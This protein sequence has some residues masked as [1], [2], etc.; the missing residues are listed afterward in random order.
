MPSAKDLVHRI[1][2]AGPLTSEEGLSILKRDRFQCQYCGLDGM[3][4]FENSL[5]MSVDFV[6]PRARKGK[7]DP[8]NL[9]AACRPC[10]VIKGRHSFESFEEA[11]EYVR[12]RREELRKEWEA[13]MAPLRTQSLTA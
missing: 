12:R 11:K 5:I 2:R 13:K 3:A 1:R 7:K 10:N 8:R 4:S 9:V 6:I